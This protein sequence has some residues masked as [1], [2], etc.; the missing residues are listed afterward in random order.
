MGF[1]NPNIL[2]LIYGPLRTLARNRRGNLIGML[3]HLAVL[4]ERFHQRYVREEEE[5]NWT[6]DFETSTD[7]FDRV[8]TMSPRD[9]AIF[10]TKDDLNAF[11]PLDPQSIIYGDSNL[12][13]LHRQWNRR[14]HETRE[15]IVAERFL[16]ACLV[17]VAQVSI[18]TSCCC[19]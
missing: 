17:D 10:I 2:K 19:F 1:P 15:S 18:S 5:M 3:K 16:G 9:L 4:E 12:Q 13:R 14:C 7:F 8:T 11:G 6:C